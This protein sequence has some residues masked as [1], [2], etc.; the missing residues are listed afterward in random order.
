MTRRSLRPQASADAS[1]T[2][3]GRAQS[4]PR[5][6]GAGRERRE[7]YDPG[8]H[9]SGKSD[10]GIVPENP[11][12]KANQPAAEV[13]EGRPVAKGKPVPLTAC[14]AQYWSHAPHKVDGP[15]KAARQ[16]VIP[17]AGAVW[18]NAPSTDLCGGRRAT[19]VPT[20]NDYEHDYEHEHD[21]E[22]EQ[23]RDG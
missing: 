12:N 1:C 11:P 20:A 6:N 4:A 14:Q 10:I 8:A 9:A 15:R 3:T 13:G 7:A 21:Y 5:E 17:E 16:A 23:E 19:G 22:Q 2:R 18:S